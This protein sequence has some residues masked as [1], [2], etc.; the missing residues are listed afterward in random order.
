MSYLPKLVYMLLRFGQFEHCRY[1]GYDY[2]HATF[3]KE[4][5]IK[6]K[7]LVLNDIDTVHLARKMFDYHNICSV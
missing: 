3:V 2:F 7:Y 1:L 5:L 6:T 4:Q